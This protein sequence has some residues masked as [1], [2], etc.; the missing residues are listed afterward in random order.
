MNH[1][2]KV[3]ILAISFDAEGMVNSSIAYEAQNRQ[4]EQ[5]EQSSTT[6]TWDP[7]ESRVK[8]ARD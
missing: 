2:D 5:Q 7:P 8:K 4:A 3:V 1:G 6:Q